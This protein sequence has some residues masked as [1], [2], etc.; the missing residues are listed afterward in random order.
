M[1]CSP[2]TDTQTDRYESD[3][4]GHPFRVSGAFPS[5]YHQGSAQYIKDTQEQE[6]NTVKIRR[7]KKT[8]I[9]GWSMFILSQ[10]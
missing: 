8:V 9:T 3:Y 4:C 6:Q 5:T 7:G 10:W 2:R 1:L